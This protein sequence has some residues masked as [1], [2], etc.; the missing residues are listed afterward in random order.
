MPARN[1]GRFLTSNCA[2]AALIS[3]GSVS[4]AVEGPAGGDVEGGLEVPAP[5]RVADAEDRR[6][7]AQVPKVLACRAALQID[8]EDGIVHHRAEAW[9]GHAAG[10]HAGAQ[11]GADVVVE[12]VEAVERRAEH[13]PVALRW[14]RRL[15]ARLRAVDHRC[16]QRDDYGS[17]GN[18]ASDCRRSVRLQWQPQQRSAAARVGTVLEAQRAAVRLGDLA[19]QHEPMPEPCG[20]VVKNG[21]NRLAGVGQARPVVLDEELHEARARDV[22]PADAHAAAAADSSTASAPFLTG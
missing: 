21:T 4:D 5:D 2:F 3:C 13:Q 20:L 1:N 6:A 16:E 12:G 19:R 14:A 7:H 18:Q 8:L 17:R 15:C 22:V 9:T 10:Q 11:I